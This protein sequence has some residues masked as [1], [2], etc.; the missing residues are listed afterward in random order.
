MVLS[1]EV[2]G[3]MGNLAIL[4]GPAIVLGL[5]AGVLVYTQTDPGGVFGKGFPALLTGG[6]V[7]IATFL[8]CGGLL[9]LR[10]ILWGVL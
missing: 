7:G 5:G 9:L 6:M 8:I 10:W 3:D 4:L 2:L 1:S